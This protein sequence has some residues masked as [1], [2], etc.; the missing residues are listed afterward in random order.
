MIIVGKRIIKIYEFYNIYFNYVFYYKKNYMLYLCN[1]V[2][3]SIKN[4]DIHTIFYY[5]IYIYNK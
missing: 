2:P 4:N 5:W 3:A 1:Y